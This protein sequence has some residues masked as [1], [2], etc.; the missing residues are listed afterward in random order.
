MPIN[1]AT[2]PSFFNAFYVDKNESNGLK[3]IL[4][5]NLSRVGGGNDKDYYHQP[6]GEYGFLALKKPGDTSILKREIEAKK[7]ITERNQGLSKF[8]P[9]SQEASHKIY[10]PG[11]IVEHIDFAQDKSGNNAEF[12][13]K[14]LG[15]GLPSD[16]KIKKVLSSVSFSGVSVV[17]LRDE[18]NE[19]QKNIDLI[20]DC[21]GELTLAVTKKDNGTSIKIIDLAPNE[22]GQTVDDESRDFI[23]SGISNLIEKLQ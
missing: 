20:C 12:K 7:S 23:K 9:E 8:F 19:I 14:F 16:M 4:T 2:S 15:M 17:K 3:S 5:E 13:P 21:V 22:S 6:G 18:L 11:F 10:G 1:S